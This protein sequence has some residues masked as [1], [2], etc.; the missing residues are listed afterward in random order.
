[1]EFAAHAMTTLIGSLAMA[2][3]PVYVALQIWLAMS[4]KNGWRRVSFVPVVFAVPIVGWC[5]FALAAGSNLWPLPFILFA[6]IGAGYLG[7]LYCL[8]VLFRRSA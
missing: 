8:T 1:M 7:V 4:L 5:I 2:A 3:V 6:P